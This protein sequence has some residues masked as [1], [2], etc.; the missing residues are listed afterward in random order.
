[1]IQ[2]ALRLMPV[3]DNLTW[4]QTWEWGEAMDSMKHELWLYPTFP[5]LEL[6]EGHIYRMVF[7][8]EWYLSEGAREGA[9]C[10]VELRLKW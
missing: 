3:D 7:G 5:D 2:D 9:W 4:I 10:N 8:D 6:D 1:M